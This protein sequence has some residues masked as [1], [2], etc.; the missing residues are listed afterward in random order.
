MI[1]TSDQFARVNLNGLTC[2]VNVLKQNTMVFRERGRK[3]KLHITQSASPL[4]L[5]KL[6]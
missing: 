1:L 6:L 5:V 2:P 3:K 4:I